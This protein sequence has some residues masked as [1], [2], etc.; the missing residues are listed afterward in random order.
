M[1]SIAQALH[2][3]KLVPGSTDTH[4]ICGFLERANLP[5]EVVAF[6]ACVLEGLSERFMSDWREEMDLLHQ[7]DGQRDLERLVRRDVSHCNV[8]PDLIVLAALAL[9]HGFQ[10]DRMRSSRHWSVK[11]SDGMFGVREIE[12]TERAMLRDMDYGLYR[13]KEEAVQKMVGEMGSQRKARRGTMSI[14]LKGT[15]IWSHGV[16][17]PEPSP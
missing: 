6:A 2:L 16:Q 9:A 12:A 3:S 4:V 15:A 1:L 17:T 14:D 7:L 8:T 13:I 11:E 10:T 5:A